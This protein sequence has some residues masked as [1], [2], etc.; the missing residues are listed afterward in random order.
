MSLYDITV[1]YTNKQLHKKFVDYLGQIV[2]N[3]LIYIGHLDLK[4][5]LL[6]GPR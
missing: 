5:V 1:R 6:I 2:Y 3:S 4:K